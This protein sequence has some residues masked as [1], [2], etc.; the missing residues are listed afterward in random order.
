MFRAS[1]LS[2][3]FNIENNG[4]MHSNPFVAINRPQIFLAAIWADCNDCGSGVNIAPILVNTRPKKAIV[5]DQTDHFTPGELHKIL[6]LLINQ[7][8]VN[9]KI[10]PSGPVRG[11]Y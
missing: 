7:E 4:E 2:L 10:G 11:A 9:L 6:A 1:F 8:L 5:M 3:A